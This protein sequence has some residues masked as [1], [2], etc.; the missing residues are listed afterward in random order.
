MEG[1]DRKGGEWFPKFTDANFLTY[2]PDD[3]PREDMEAALHGRVFGYAQR[4]PEEDAS[5]C[6]GIRLQDHGANAGEIRH[7]PVNATHNGAASNVYRELV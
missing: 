4:K 2:A 3:V 5:R 1:E 7:A 6:G